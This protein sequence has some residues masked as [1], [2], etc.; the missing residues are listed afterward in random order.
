MSLVVAA[1]NSK[2]IVI[3]YESKFDLTKD[4]RPYKTNDELMKVRR[5][6]PQLAF[7]VT[8]NYN[9]DKLRLFKSLVTNVKNLS[10]YEAFLVLD[11][12][13]R[14]L[15]LLPNEGLRM[16][17]AGYMSTGPCF[18]SITLVHGREPV[19]HESRAIYASGLKEAVELSE[20]LLNGIN[21]HT[22]PNEIES[23]IKQALNECI[24]RFPETL[25]PPVEIMTLAKQ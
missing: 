14:Q 23:K 19:L 8:G 24:E 20:Q 3:G 22:P 25:G 9:S 18:R 6:N 13:G 10:F 4:G 17:L 21:E 1:C 5:I 7:I 12:A 15:P 16:G 2:E 11:G